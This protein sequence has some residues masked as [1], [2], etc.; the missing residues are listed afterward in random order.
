VNK[1]R[2]DCDGAAR[3][4]KHMFRTYKEPGSANEICDAK[5][6]S[7]SI[8]QRVRTRKEPG[9]ANEICTVPYGTVL[10]QYRTVRY[11]TVSTVRYG[12]GT[13]T[14]LYC[15][16]SCRTVSEYRSPYGMVPYCTLPYGTVQYRY[17]TGTIQYRY[18]TVAQ[19]SSRAEVTYGTAE[20]VLYH[21]FV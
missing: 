4:V 16:V 13:G 17:G 8:K 7:E 11:P 18:C 5:Y 21:T 2:C 14:V 10:Y 1:K 15:T 9:R 12:I 3:L 19:S 6:R 20:Y